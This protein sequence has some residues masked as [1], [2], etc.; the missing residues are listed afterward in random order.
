[1]A[2]NLTEDER[3]ALQEKEEN[4]SKEVRCPRCGG[5][6]SY[7]EVGTSYTVYCETDGCIKMSVRG[8]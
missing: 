2:I 3:K 6:I 5:V 8:I 4:P 1:M 7:R